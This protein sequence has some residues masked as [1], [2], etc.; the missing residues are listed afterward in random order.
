MRR[1]GPKTIQRSAGSTFGS[2]LPLKTKAPKKFQFFLFV[3]YYTCQTSAT[4][5]EKVHVIYR[6]QCS[7]SCR[8]L[9]IAMPASI[10]KT[11]DLSHQLEHVLLWRHAVKC[12]LDLASCESTKPRNCFYSDHFQIL[13]SS[14]RQLLKFIRK[15]MQTKREGRASCSMFSCF[16]WAHYNFDSF[17]LGGSKVERVAL[18]QKQRITTV[19]KRVWLTNHV[20]SGYFFP[21]L[22]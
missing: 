17:W 11:C 16:N 2:S 7:F 6:C 3:V 14:W 22:V 15:K 21:G 19:N 8:W 1:S 5:S 13:I 9:S 12:S 10:W 18:T 20:N 4:R